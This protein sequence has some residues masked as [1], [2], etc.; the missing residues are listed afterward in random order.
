MVVPCRDPKATKVYEIMSKPLITGDPE[1]D[2]EYA[3]RFMIE[4]NVKRLPII[5]N[6]R[7]AGIV[8]FTDIVR[9][10]PQIVETL[11]KTLAAM[12]LPKRFEKEVT[13]KYY[14]NE[15]AKECSLVK[16]MRIEEGTYDDWKQL[17]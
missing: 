9:F 3:A 11:E 2:L 17:A 15:L 16:E 4:K 7:L 8:T 1:M 10:R 14:P 12:T 13:V 6:G 5:E